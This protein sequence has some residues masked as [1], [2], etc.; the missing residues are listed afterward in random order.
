MRYLFKFAVALK[1]AQVPSTA[2]GKGWNDSGARWQRKND[3]EARWQV[4]NTYDV[5]EKFRRRNSKHI[6]ILS[7][8]LQQYYFRTVID[9]FAKNYT[10]IQEYFTLSLRLLLY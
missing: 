8:A 6:Y 7:Y 3:S 2:K 4:K 10:A 9:A 5:E 1:V